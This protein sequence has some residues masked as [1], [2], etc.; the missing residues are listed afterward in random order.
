ML[1]KFFKI[2]YNKS[3]S[4]FR[5]IFF[6]RFLFTVF[7][8]SF[9][10]FLIIPN[11][12]NYEKKASVILDKLNQNYNL[13]I[14]KYETIKFK[15]FPTPRF[16]LK[17]VSAYINKSDIKIDTKNLKIF[18]NFLT[19]Y[20][21]DKFQIKKIILKKNNVA[22]ETSNLNYFINELL[23]K[24]NKLSVE[25]LDIEIKK[26]KKLIVKLENIKFTNYG[27]KLN[28]IEGKIFK[29][30]FK[31]K[32][33]DNFKNLKFTLINSGMDVDI[34]LDENKN[35]NLISGIFKTKILNT[36]IKFNFDYNQKVLNID[37]TVFRSKYLSFKNNNV[38]FLEPFLDMRSS[39]DINQIDFQML[40]K[41][42]FK[43]ILEKR[44]IIKKI[45]SKN[46]IKFKS[47]KFSRDLI[48]ELSLKI[49]LAYG[50]MSYVKKI[51]ISENL[52][53]C[54]GDTNLL[55]EY[56]LIFFNCSLISEN[57]QK[58]LKEFNIKSK[59]KDKNLEISIK[60]NLNILNKKINFKKIEINQNYKASKEDLIY[61]KNA[62][63]NILF[64]ET[65]IQIFNLKKIKKFILE[66]S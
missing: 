10:L 57:K 23:K 56:P 48:D 51:L 4:F 58:L 33:K 63:E 40:K 52:I 25:N 49:S 6:L 54:K 38:I 26:K 60:G 21:F 27:S 30:K 59:N 66:I 24:K 53:Q 28:I 62:F 44:N 22:L 19:I 47:E 55:D 18:P 11:F 35:S 65:F 61:F 14:D 16:E 43:K 50:R 13:K 45:N 64:N 15:S 5:F 9:L 1:N 34:N 31:V 37:N 3:Y 46:E 7:F 32:L 39:F 29:K 12:F 17:N 41:I 36:N 42:N 8:V 20:N 2:I